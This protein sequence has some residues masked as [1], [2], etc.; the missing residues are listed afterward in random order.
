MAA[1]LCWRGNLVSPR[2]GLSWLDMR[3]SA[4]LQAI[5]T[6]RRTLNVRS[7]IAIRTPDLKRLTPNAT[8]GSGSCSKLDLPTQMEI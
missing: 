4:R 2:Q 1:P 8:I 5:P 3:L 6:A 7:Q